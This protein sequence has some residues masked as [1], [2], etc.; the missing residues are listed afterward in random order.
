MRNFATNSFVL[1]ESI[2]FLKLKKLKRMKKIFTLIAVA[3]MAM[4]ANAQ[5][6]FAIEEGFIPDDAGQTLAANSRKNSTSVAITFGADGK[7]SS[8]NSGAGAKAD[9]SVEGFTAY[10]S[11]GNNPKDGELDGTSS[12][13]GGYTI[14]KKNLPK[15]G[16]YYVFTPTNAGSL[17]V[18]I[19]LNA[20]KSFYI[21]KEDGAAMSDFD[22]KDKD[23]NTVALRAFEQD[24]A[25]FASSENKVYGL[26]R[27]NV[28]A[29]K[30][31]TVFCTGS[32][33]GIYGFT[34]SSEAVVIDPVT[35]AA[36]KAE[37]DAAGGET[38][39]NAVKVDSENAVIYNLAGQKVGK[40]Y[41]GVVIVNGRK[42]IQK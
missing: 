3:A 2:S 16:C 21:V 28:E 39:I 30:S 13:G 25:Q 24:A 31:Y 38:A 15:S 11:G 17:N 7:W 19:Q 12:T 14:E 4:S 5:E 33:L 41:K 9:T 40:D 35:T 27:F 20:N 36:V 8:F 18:A 10:I 29:G 34:Y 1:T 6:T 42:M 26:A 23:G 32:K 22:I 37:I